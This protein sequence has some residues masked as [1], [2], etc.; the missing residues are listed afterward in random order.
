MTTR[1]EQAYRALHNSLQAMAEGSDACPD[2]VLRNRSVP[3]LL[4]T[5]RTGTVAFL[6]LLDDT[7]RYLGEEVA[8]PDDLGQVD[9]IQPATLEIAVL[10]PADETREA[11]FDGIMEA[12]KEYFQTLDPSLGGLVDNV[13]V[14]EPPQRMILRGDVAVKA[15]SVRI[16]MTLSVPTVFG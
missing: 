4:V 2:V 5:S 12:L 8:G 7:G 6:N 3:D 16:E 9:M 15:A 14:I 10:N 1:V 13:E 11:Q